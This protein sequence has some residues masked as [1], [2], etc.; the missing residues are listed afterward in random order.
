MNITSNKTNKDNCITVD[1]E[2]CARCGLDHKSLNF[3]PLF[4]PVEF[5][6][7][8]IYT[9]WRACPTNMQPILLRIE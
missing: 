5:E 2:N 6:N 1:V 7:E 4:R 9:H 3:V 8:I